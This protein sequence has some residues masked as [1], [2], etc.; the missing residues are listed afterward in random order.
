M[1]KS[2]AD[3]GSIVPGLSNKYNSIKNIYDDGKCEHL[4]VCAAWRSDLELVKKADLSICLSSAPEYVQKEC[5]LVINGNSENLLKV[6]NKIYHS[7]NVVK[8]IN[9]FKNKKHI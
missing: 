6:I 8:T 4:I 2:M 1:E 5:D 7:N 9:S 3:S